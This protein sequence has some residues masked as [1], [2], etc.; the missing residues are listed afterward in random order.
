MDLDDLRRRQHGVVSRRQALAAGLTEHALR[1]RVDH[2]RWRRV[3]DG[4]YLTHA[5]ELSWMARG[6][7]A[8]LHGGSGAGLGM[9]AAAHVHGLTDRPPAGI[10][11]LVPEQ[12]RVVSDPPRLQ[13]TRRRGLV[14]VQVRGLALTSVEDTVLDLGGIRGATLDDAVAHAARA[15]QRRRT[16]AGRLASALERRARHP[17]RDGLR[18][19]LGD[20][21]SGAESILEVAFVRDVVRRHGLPP[22]RMQVPG[23]CA[24]R[25]VRRDFVDDERRVIVE[26]DGV[27]GHAGPGMA[28]DRRRDRAAA[29]D[30]WLSLRCG[31]VDVRH[32]ACELALDL[33]LTLRSRGWRGAPRPCGPRCA[34]R[35]V[36]Q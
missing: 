16:T 6:W 32:G 3:H 28:A 31:W 1:W 13:V 23:D 10:V 14:T 22:L 29:R 18:L 7:A 27:L 17:H 15:V 33:A 25:P 2:G 19:A 5:G 20:I 11:L 21:D 9:L 35:A 4:V 34:V 8:A 36:P 26:V 30:G 12:R 24:G